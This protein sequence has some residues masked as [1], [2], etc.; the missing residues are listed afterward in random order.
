MIMMM[1]LWVARVCGWIVS[2][3]SWW[4]I[5]YLFYVFLLTVCSIVYLGNAWFLRTSKRRTLDASESKRCKFDFLFICR[6]KYI[7]CKFF[8]G[9]HDLYSIAC[10]HILWYIYVQC[11]LSPISFIYAIFF[12][13]F[14]FLFT[15]FFFHSWFFFLLCG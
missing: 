15:C 7:L 12:F 10:I 3:L 4:F 11:I 6:C 13:L 9:E 8:N 5:M 14:L 1:Y 2:I